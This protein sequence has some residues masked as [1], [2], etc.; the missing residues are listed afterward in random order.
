MNIAGGQNESLDIFMKSFN[1]KHYYF[2]C[3]CASVNSQ[4]PKMTSSDCA[5]IAK[6]VNTIDFDKFDILFY[7]RSLLPLDIRFSF[8]ERLN[9]H[10]SFINMLCVSYF[11]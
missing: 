2:V 4:F 9:F 1:F 6:L 5:T 11:D 7:D 3:V 10:C 8:V